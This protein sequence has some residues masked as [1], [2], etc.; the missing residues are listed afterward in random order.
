MIQLF[1]ETSTA[2]VDP[3]I[4]VQH[5]DRKSTGTRPWVYTNMVASAD[6]GT[7]VDGVSGALGG[8]G[9]Q[10][11]FGALRSMADIILAGSSTV[12][13][14]RYR[15][16]NP[17]AETKR[18]RLHRGQ[19]ERPRIAVVSGRLDIDLDLP[20][21]EDPTHRPLIIAPETADPALVARL[22]P[23]ADFIRAGDGRV[24]LAAAMVALAE[25]GV[26]TVLCEGGPSINGQMIA[27]GLIDEW[28]LTISPHLVGGDSKRAAV[29][30]VPE[31]P[32]PG[33]ELRRVWNDDDHL[34]CRW[35]R[36]A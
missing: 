16:P 21:F 35:T 27:A 12:T 13:Q 8:P 24:D 20:L 19:A 18:Q 26:G 9:D 33:M 17:S 30:P 25:M 32:P 7:A 31:G 2:E 23:A 11:V 1:P 4:A 29:G 34:F 36:R 6:G 28:N 22:E 5:E 10:E 14:E 15:T 3:R